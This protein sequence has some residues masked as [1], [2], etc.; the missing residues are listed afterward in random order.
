MKIT[1]WLLRSEV[2]LALQ[3]RLYPLDFLMSGDKVRAR[4]KINIPCGEEE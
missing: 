2:N 3:S 1:K 4:V